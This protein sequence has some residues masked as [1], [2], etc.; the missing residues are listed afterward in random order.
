M[1][2]L[3]WIP[4]SAALLFAYACSRTQEEEI[5]AAAATGTAQEEAPAAVQLGLSQPALVDTKAAVDAWSGNEKL[6]IFGF[7]LEND[8][9]ALPDESFIF[10]VPAM[11]PA[12]GTSGLI[13]LYNPEVSTDNYKEPFYYTE[14]VNY[15]F[16]GYHVGDG[17]YMENDGVTPRIQYEDSYN[18]YYATLSINGTQDVMVGTTPD[19][20]A[21]ADA[22][23]VNPKRIYSAFAARRGVHPELVFQHVLSRFRF[24]VLSGSQTAASS[25]TVDA[26]QVQSNSHAFLFVAGPAV[27]GQVIQ[28]YNLLR[29]MDLGL[30]QAYTLPALGDQPIELPGSIMVMPGSTIYPIK[31]HMNQNGI[32][33]SAANTQ[34]FEIDFERLLQSSDECA[35]AGHQ[36]WITITV[37]GLEAVNITVSLTPWDEGGSVEVDPDKDFVVSTQNPPVADAA[38]GALDVP[39][40]ATDQYTYTVDAS[41]VHVVNNAPAPAPAL[42]KADVIEE[43]LHF[44]LD[45]NPGRYRVAKVNFYV[46]G[47]PDYG[48]TIS[49]NGAQDFP[50]ELGIYPSQGEDYVFNPV[51]DLVSVYQVSS[52]CWSRFLFPATNTV[53]ELGPIPQSLS[54]DQ[55]FDASFTVSVNGQTTSSRDITV[56]VIEIKDNKVKLLDAEHLDGYT[57]IF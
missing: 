10:N 21:I 11:S 7:P 19:R 41:W 23:G 36:Y 31:L 2:R 57:I 44:M 3:I 30:T 5:P 13:N 17:A 28:Q 53:Y 37:Y 38:G 27:N 49:Q 51:T 47:E 32:T 8:A 26:I 16:Y 4:L 40:V 39:I 14:K 6:F 56:R 33:E 43:T 50:D 42:T 34:E 54:L 22:T 45:P 12:T 24:R 1:H 15:A 18:G 52:Q 9:P 29:W 20:N 25:V 46:N 55:E 35:T 48:F